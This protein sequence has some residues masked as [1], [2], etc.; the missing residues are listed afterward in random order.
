[1]TFALKHQRRTA[2]TRRMGAALQEADRDRQTMSSAIDDAAANLERLLEAVGPGQSPPRAAWEELAR[3]SSAA[4]VRGA[5]S[6]SDWR[7]L[8]A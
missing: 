3:L 2:D 1:V 6:H 8:A 7:Q 5:L 4:S